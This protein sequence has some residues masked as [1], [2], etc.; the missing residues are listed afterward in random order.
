MPEVAVAMETAEQQAEPIDC[1]A[2]PPRVV[3]AP[4]CASR[5]QRDA[6]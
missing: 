6:G 1:S 5:R 3:R 2:T 4:R